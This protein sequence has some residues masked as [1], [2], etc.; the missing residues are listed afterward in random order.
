MNLN[1]RQKIYL[2]LVIFLVCFILIILCIFFPL[3]ER[4][5]RE[6]VAFQEARGRL[7][8]LREE[9][10]YL[11]QLKKDYESVRDDFA[12]FKKAFLSSDEIVDFIIN[13][14]EIAR[15][16]NLYQ[17]IQ[18]YT[19]QKSKLQ[20]EEGFQEN[21]LEFILK[22][23]GEFKD[24]VNYMAYLE[25]MDYYTE[26]EEIQ[27]KRVNEKNLSSLKRNQ[28]EHNLSSG[29]ILTNLKIKVYLREEKN[30]SME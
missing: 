29:D 15:N 4:I 18:I 20:K 27:I 7:S 26:T 19:P 14:E 21:S 13:L 16:T 24:L 25:N 3:I 30:D 11:V 8:V 2:N 12:R 28:K 5:K 6:S 17:E 23:E 22:L 1:T 10:V 9:A